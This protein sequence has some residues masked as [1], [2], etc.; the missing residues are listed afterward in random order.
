MSRVKDILLAVVL[1]ATGPVSAATFFDVSVDLTS[2]GPPY[3]TSPTQT[4]LFQGGTQVGM[5]NMGLHDVSNAPLAAYIR[6]WDPAGGPGALSSSALFGVFIEASQPTPPSGSS[7]Y[8]DI[9]VQPLTNDGRPGSIQGAS[10]GGGGGGSGGGSGG[11]FFSYF[12]VSMNVVTDGAGPRSLRLRSEAPAGQPVHFDFAGGSIFQM[13]DGRLHI[14]P[15]LVFDGPVENALPLF[16]ITMTP[17][18]ASM[19]LLLAGAGLLRRRST[20]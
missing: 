17:E 8:F 13:I 9:W 4:K 14:A 3:P 6:A 2:T 15:K 20:R 7:S 11:G 19:L 12:S 16:T 1:A 18:P 5:L 10:G